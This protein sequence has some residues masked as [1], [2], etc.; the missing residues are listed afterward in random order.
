MIGE[1][2]VAAQ[3]HFDERGEVLG[4]V[5][6]Q[7]ESDC[8]IPGIFLQCTRNTEGLWTV[9][10]EH[11]DTQKPLTVIGQNCRYTARK[12]GWEITRK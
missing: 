4:V 1:L 6:N 12:G 8:G 2:S 3:K 10:I 7:H 9:V 11:Y 5:A